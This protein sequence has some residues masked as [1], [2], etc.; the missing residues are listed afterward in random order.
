MRGAP[1]II[2][3]IGIALSLF[4]VEELRRFDDARVHTALDLRTDLRAREIQRNI[5]RLAVPLG[6]LAVLMASQ[7]EMTRD[8]FQRFALGARQDGVPI[9]RLSWMPRVTRDEQAG[10]ETQQRTN[11]GADFRIVERRG[12][13][14]VPV[15]ERTEYFPVVYD[16]S[17]DDTVSERGLD[18]ASDPSR[19]DAMMQAVDAGEPV[20]T[21]P[22]RSGLASEPQPS[23]VVFAPV[24]RSGAV[25]S[26][27]GERRAKL[28]GFVAGALR[29]ASAF[30]AAMRAAPLAGETLRVYMGH[31]AAAAQNEPPVVVYLPTLKRFVAGTGEAALAAPD[32]RIVVSSFREFGQPW[33]LALEVPASI[34]AGMRSP[35]TVALPAALLVMTLLLVAYCLVEQRR[36]RAAEREVVQR[37][38][39]VSRSKEALRREAQERESAENE[40]ARTSTILERIVEASPMAIICVTPN[41]NVVI[42]NRAAEK[43]FGYSAEEVI[44]RPYSLVPPEARDEFDR[45]FVEALSGEVQQGIEMQHRRKDGKLIDVLFSGA[46]VYDETDA[47]RGVIYELEDVTERKRVEERLTQA[48]K[49]ESVGQLTGGLAHDFNNILGAVIGNL[50]LLEERLGEDKVAA[51]YAKA[52]LDAALAGAE[53]VKR[54]LAFSRRQPLKPART[55][56]RTAIRDFLPLL[57][58]TLGEQVRIESR[59]ASDCWPVMTDAVQ[60]E[61]AVLNLA[62]NARDAM[63]YGG[64]AK[65]ECRNVVIDEGQAQAESDLVAGDYVVL[66]VADSGTGMTP[67]VM[68]HAFEPFFTT[69][70]QGAGTGLGLSMIFGYAKQSGGTVKLTSEQGKGTTVRLYLPRAADD[71]EADA[72]GEAG[73][74]AEPTGTERILYVEDNPQIRRVGEAMLRKLGYSVTVAPTADAALDLFMRDGDYDLLFS[75]VV[76][77]GRLNGAGLGRELRARNPNI[78]LL[79]ASGFASPGVGRDKLEAMGAHLITKPYRRGELARTLREILDKA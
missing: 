53:L 69:K 49:M 19:R 41:R 21:E 44:G 17:F 29:F 68:A 11:G 50:D 76:M 43:T 48:E 39:E 2:A 42:W 56:L 24:Y 28:I 15:E 27:V 79:F 32:S 78:K 30:D 59:I 72:R 70:A 4:A 62:V 52:S 13:E 37:T 34:V 47:L 75:D 8:D 9:N 35:V 33:T 18:A 60:L 14:L 36:K 77:P 31:L 40:L 3:V 22:L 54:L 71:G 65:I 55:D 10:F 20:A 5:D 45:L 74:L 16:V 63:P 51:G 38:G 25:P 64:T 1:W 58:R 12:N 73:A 67:E 6:E 23:Y 26:S 61:S 46:A 7:R 57:R 66:S